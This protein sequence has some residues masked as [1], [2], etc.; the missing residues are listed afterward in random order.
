MF[1]IFMTS[2]LENDFSNPPGNIEFANIFSN[3]GKKLKQKVTKFGSHSLSGFRVAANTM[4][5]GLS[6]AVKEFFE[7]DF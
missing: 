6:L 3:C 1:L 2:R 7:T 5:K 4:A